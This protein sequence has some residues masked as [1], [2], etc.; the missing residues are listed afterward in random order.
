MLLVAS[1]R[2]TCDTKMYHMCYNTATDITNAYCEDSMHTPTA[3]SHHAHIQHTPSNTTLQHHTCQSH[4]HHLLP[5]TS[6]LLPC[7]VFFTRAALLSS[8]NH[9]IEGSMLDHSDGCQAVAQSLLSPF[10]LLCCQ[11]LEWILL[12]LPPA[13]HIF[14]HVCCQPDASH[15]AAAAA[16]ISALGL[17]GTEIVFSDMTVFTIRNILRWCIKPTCRL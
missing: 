16:A 8:M 2:D 5:L 6:L 15:H 12:L 10:A 17:C 3:S 14:R 1:F 13:L 9:L 7:W 11:Q 4:S